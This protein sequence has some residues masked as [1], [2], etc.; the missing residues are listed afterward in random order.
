M[1]RDVLTNAE[2]YL[3]ALISRTECS[4]A[5]PGLSLVYTNSFLHNSV[6]R[7]IIQYNHFPSLLSGLLFSSRTKYDVESIEKE[8]GHVTLGFSIDSRGNHLLL[9]LCRIKHLICRIIIIILMIGPLIFYFGH[10]IG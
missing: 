8:Q 1:P 10:C 2:L 3:G 4:D 9:S 7:T 6:L 5:F